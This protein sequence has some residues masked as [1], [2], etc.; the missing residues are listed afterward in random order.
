MRRY[1]TIAF[2]LLLTAAS[3]AQN[4]NPTVQVVNDFEGKLM[5]IEKQNLPMAVPDS[6][7]QF[8]WNFNYSVFDNPYKGAYEFNPYLIEMKPDPVPYDG[9]KLYVRAGAGYT[10]HP[11]LQAVWS[12]TFKNGLKLSVY[13]S[14]KGYWGKY[15]NLN[16]L[17]EGFIKPAGEADGNESGN[18]FGVSAR[19]DF[20]PVILS[21]DGKFDWLD[22]RSPYEDRNS[23]LG[24][25][26]SFR[27]RSN[28]A[29]SFLFDVEAGY[30]NLSDQSHWVPATFTCD[31]DFKESGFYADGSV[32]YG[33]SEL[34]ST[35]LS[36]S[37]ENFLFRKPGVNIHSAMLDVMPFVTYSTDRFA[38][39]VGVKYSDVFKGYDVDKAMLSTDEDGNPYFPMAD[40]QGRKLPVYPQ[41]HFAVEAV[42][43]ALQISADVTGGKRYNTY[44]GY[45]ESNH[46]FSGMWADQIP[47]L[48]GDAS[49]NTVDASLGL[50]GRITSKLH[51]VLKGG[52]AKWKN[53]PME[54]LMFSYGTIDN[55]NYDHR[56][57]SPGYSM[58]DMDLYYGELNA[59]WKS[60]RLDVSGLFRLQESDLA[61]SIH[62]AMTLPRFSGSADFTYNWNRRLFV[63]VSAE[64]A[65]KRECTLLNS[66]VLSPST[67]HARITAPGW[68]DL[69]VNLEYWITGGMSLWLKGGNLL[70]QAVMRNMLIAEKGPFGTI[71]ICLNL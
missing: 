23:V 62:G 44:S 13:D 27:A 50:D 38:A 32:S 40:Y 1:I 39:T 54:G 36:S 11:E 53:L 61:E 22:S 43:D 69:G 42:E 28:N 10:L 17:N 65:T 46:F 48:L 4:L 31:S 34:L 56:F 49:E 57:V 64:W 9:K 47:D 16:T 15:H 67:E 55:P 33:F 25:S 19:Y 18:R 30:K 71:G 26:I 6:L 63:G 35:G 29:K 37:Y 2:G 5:E 24:E 70:N 3:F 45:L 41:L 14:F 20:K 52:I 58:V 66:T 51:F 21:L 8:D 59:L 60:D 7:T 12:P 68:V